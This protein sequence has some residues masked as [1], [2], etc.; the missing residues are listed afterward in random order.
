MRKTG[1][2]ILVSCLLLAAACGNSES[3][4]SDNASGGASAP[5]VTDDTIKVGGVGSLTNPIGVKAGSVFDGAK[6]Y[7]DI[8]NED[9]GVDGREIELVA[10]ED[11]SAQASRNTSLVRSLV[12][13]EDVFAVLPVATITPFP[14]A[15]F[16]AD[17]SV[18]TFG[19]NLSPSWADKPTLFGEKGSF[20]CF[21]CASPFLPYL[22]R[23]L[24][25]PR[26]GIIAYTA[27]QS[28]ACA[29]GQK[30]SYEE[31]AD[32]TGVEL[33]FE[34][35]SLGFGFTPGALDA[36]LRTMRDRGVQFLSTCIDG[37]G[38]GRLAD[39]I[40][41][42]GLDIVQYLPNGYDPDI[43]EEF[44]DVLDGGVASSFAFPFEDE[45]PPEA[46]ERYKAAMED[47]G[48]EINELSMAGWLSADLF[49]TGL[50]AVAEAGDELTRENLVKTINAMK[51]YDAGGLLAGTDWT[52]SHDQIPPQ[53]CLTF[54]E[55]TPDG[56]API[57]GEPGKPFVCLDRDDPDFDRPEIRS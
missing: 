7:L 3:D 25:R 52:I 32:E 26:V 28:Q 54:V 44:G 19:L 11:D 49:V 51:D 39:A 22:A 29:E 1:I 36:D 46:M 34:D 6:A 33:V 35:T 10:E 48:S 24:E 9:G 8:V 53:P 40:D 55:I 17:Q 43:V 16:L 27:A 4:P 30:N 45:Q 12:Q 47:T 41:R 38:S 14:G 18:P 42:A 37:A 50:R 5:G 23:E 20:L 15:E 57:L 21:D 56:F 13:Q 2:T 31:F